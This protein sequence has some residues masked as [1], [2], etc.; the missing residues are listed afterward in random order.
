MG[1]W[2]MNKESLP[3]ILG[4]LIPIALLTVILLFYYG[5]DITLFLR[6]FPVIYYIVI[7]PFAIGFLVIIVKVLRPD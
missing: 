3:L 2:I 1:M 4:I 6:Q 5:F 7:I